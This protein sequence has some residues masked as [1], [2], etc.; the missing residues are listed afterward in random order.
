MNDVRTQEI[1][2]KVPAVTFGFWII[3]IA[4]T[5]LGGTGGDSVTMTLNWGYLSGTALF[6]AILIVLVGAQMPAR[7]FQPAAVALT[8]QP[9]SHRP[10][11][12]RPWRTLRIARWGSATRAAK[13]SCS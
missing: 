13:P 11:S 3:K 5:T 8:G 2:S 10:R 6:L 1:L 4:A 12:V 9:S 7:K